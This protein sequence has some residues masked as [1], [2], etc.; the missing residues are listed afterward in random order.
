MGPPAAKE[1]RSSAVE[2]TER[3]T[4]KI[5]VGFEGMDVSKFSSSVSIFDTT[6]FSY[7]YL[8]SLK[9]LLLRDTT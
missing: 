8:L 1:E 7:I 4:R 9:R 6:P 2:A 5:C 3:T